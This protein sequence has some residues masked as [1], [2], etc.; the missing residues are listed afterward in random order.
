MFREQ[1]KRI[2]REKILSRKLVAEEHV[3]VLMVASKKVW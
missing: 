2:T 1:K 3:P